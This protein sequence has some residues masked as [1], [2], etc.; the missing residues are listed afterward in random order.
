MEQTRE[1]AVKASLLVRSAH[2]RSKVHPEVDVSNTDIQAAMLNFKRLSEDEKETWID[3]ELENNGYI[4]KEYN[5]ESIL[6]EELGQE[7]RLMLPYHLK[8]LFPDLQDLRVAFHTVYPKDGIDD[9][10]QV[11]EEQYEEEKDTI[12]KLEG[13]LRCLK[14][15]ET[16]VSQ[17]QQTSL[18]RTTTMTN[19]TKDET[20]ENTFSLNQRKS[21]PRFGIVGDD[22]QEGEKGLV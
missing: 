18:V 3:R 15:E 11:M 7:A 17:K 21:K 12:E 14:F 16:N 5:W 22:W 9:T 20:K 2:K 19:S 6:R 10:Q 13:E 8:K 1:G 4:G